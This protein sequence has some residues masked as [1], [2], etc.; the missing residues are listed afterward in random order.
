MYERIWCKEQIDDILS[1]NGD[2]GLR[3]MN[4]LILADDVSK[5]G[6]TIYQNFFT[7]QDLAI[8][9]NAKSDFFLIRPDNV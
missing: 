1:K 6:I 4:L 7:P 9:M 5:K 3:G 8:Y 2:I